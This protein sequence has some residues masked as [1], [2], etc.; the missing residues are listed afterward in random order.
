MK[1]EM[2]EKMRGESC[3]ESCR[4]SIHHRDGGDGSPVFRKEREGGGERAR[5][6]TRRRCRYL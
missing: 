6:F 3:R 4:E 1:K 2:E 5:L